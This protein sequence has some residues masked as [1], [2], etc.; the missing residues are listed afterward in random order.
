MGRFL[1]WL[2]GA[3][4]QILAECPT[5]RPKYV[6]IGAAILITAAMAAVSLAFALVTALKV[7]LWLALPFAIAWGV[8]IMSLDRLFVVS[9][10]RKGKPSAQILRAIPRLLLA[11]LMGLVISAPFTLQIF[12]PEIEHEISVIHQQA[13]AAYYRQ[14]KTSSIQQRINQDENNVTNLEARAAGGGSGV[15]PSQDPTLENLQSQLTQA[16]AAESRDYDQWQCQLYG[17]AP[18]GQVC[19][20]PGNGVLA[21]ADEQRY[22]QDVAQVN[23]L[24]GQITAQQKQLDQSNTRVKNNDKTAAATSLPAAKQQLK[25]DQATEQAQTDAFV[26]S[27]QNNG[28][29]LIRLQ[30]LEK[31]TA[32]N[33]TLNAARWLL[34]LLFVV[35]DCMPVA[36]KVMLNL[37]PENNYDRM[38]EAEEKKQLKVAA[39]NRAL[40]Q[41][42]ETLSAEVILGEAQSRLAGWNAPIPAVTENIIAT[43]TRVENKKLHAWENDQT[44][45]LFSRD[46]TT[47]GQTPADP[48]PP[49]GF[50]PWPQGNGWAPQRQWWPG[51]ALLQNLRLLA[52]RV[53]GGGLHWHR[54][55]RARARGGPGV[56][57][58]PYGAPF[59]PGSV[60]GTHASRTPP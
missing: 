60:N 53:F 22:H 52:H 50:I 33:A 15:P 32:D 48:G 4:R 51:P 19:R 47:P 38:L 3:R 43:R 28:G 13:A 11:L 8:A 2:S 40:R 57:P 16:E 18:S 10:P 29:L 31:V 45:R 1:I 59:S 55:G 46:N 25:V 41:R 21:R 9:M 54:T 5:E 24:N 26:S 35:I 12:R 34:F 37:G 7:K 44:R 14:L 20:P 6:G 39:S 42:A 36:I 49:M 30:A 27:N 23:Q 56:G 58:R 17:R